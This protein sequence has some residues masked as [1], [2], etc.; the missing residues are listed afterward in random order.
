MT[1]S[2]TPKAHYTCGKCG[3]RWR[4][5]RTPAPVGC[6]R[7]NNYSLIGVDSDTAAALARPRRRRET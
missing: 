2:E 5:K 4:G 3:C 1:S 7:C 6:P